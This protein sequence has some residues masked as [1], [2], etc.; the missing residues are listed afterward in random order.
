MSSR[1]VDMTTNAHVFYIVGPTASG[2]SE[3]TAAVATRCDAEIVGA[4]AFQVYRGLARLTAQPDVAL[5]AAVPHHLIGTIDVTE[6]MSAAK[7]AELA[8]SAIAEIRSR[9]R[10]VIVVG[11]SG[12]YVRALTDGFSERPPGDAKLRAHLAELSLG[13]LNLRL[14]AVDSKA[15]ARID[16]NNRRR[17]ERALEICLLGAKA[18][19]EHLV[20][21]AVPGET[22]RQSG[23]VGDARRTTHAAAGVFVFRDREDLYQ[24]INL[25]VER[26]FEEGVVEEVRMSRGLGATAAQAI[27][28]REIQSLL[29]GQT[30]GPECIARIQQ[31][32]RHY[33][34][35]QLTWFRRQSNFEP[36]NL[37]HRSTAEAIEWIAQK[38]CLSFA[39]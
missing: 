26:M 1:P 30:S 10:N 23:S 24:R 3:I 14:R 39:R 28:A 18:P 34:K 13:E 33:A 7:F 27:G 4:D 12:L 21:S 17:V 19:S 29:R 5:R 11:G 25:R 8:R 16:T 37:S 36:L 35:R 9:D 2:K 22:G 6:E 15:A 32:T 31:A 20:A 38:A